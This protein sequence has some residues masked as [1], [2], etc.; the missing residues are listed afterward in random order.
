MLPNA[1]AYLLKYKWF[2][3]LKPNLTQAKW[4]PF[5]DDRLLRIMHHFYPFLFEKNQNNNE[6]LIS[7]SKIAYE[8]NKI[9]VLAKDFKNNKKCKERWNNH[10]NPFVNK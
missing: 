1:N 10:L 2:T 8:F 7:W 9:T 6:N 4:I 3:Y 5:Q